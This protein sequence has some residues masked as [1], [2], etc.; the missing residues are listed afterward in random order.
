MV[1]VVSDIEIQMTRRRRDLGVL[2]S[3]LRPHKGEEL[4]WDL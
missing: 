1:Q 4:R 2:K 3:E